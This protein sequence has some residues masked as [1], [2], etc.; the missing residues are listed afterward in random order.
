MS[1]SPRQIRPCHVGRINIS[2]AAEIVPL[3]RRAFQGCASQSPEGGSVPIPT[4]A[5]SAN[6]A[7]SSLGACH[8]FFL[9][10][11]PGI[12]GTAADGGAGNASHP[13]ASASLFRGY[14]HFA[15]AVAAIARYAA[16]ICS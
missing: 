6:L 2:Y 16:A 4:I 5:K 8:C 12:R 7:I 10:P 9:S 3:L 15:C 1:N 13:R 11:A 14:D